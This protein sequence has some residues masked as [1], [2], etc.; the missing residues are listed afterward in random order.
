MKKPSS[1]GLRLVVAS[2]VAHTVSQAALISHDSFTGYTPG[3]LPAN[4]SPAVTGYTGSWGDAAFGNAEPA[5]TSGSLTYGDG[6]YA[7]SSGDM[8]SKGADAGGIGADNSGRTFRLLDSTLAVGATTSGT[9]YLSWLFQTGNEN[10]AANPNT[11]QT[12]ALWNGDAGTDSLR[13]FEAGIAGGDFA[14]GNYGYR[15]DS[16]TPVN[17]G[18]AADAT[19]HLFV[20]KFELNATADSDSVTVWLDP[21]LGGTGDPTGGFTLSGR[22]LAWDRLVL[23]DFASNSSAWDE[24]RW[25]SDFNSVTVPEPATAALGS[26]AVLI[27]LRRRRN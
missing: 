21:A 7:G 20:A 16:N 17:L 10:A 23:S 2:L 3:Y 6:L 1:P 14:T 26:L 12:L 15:V 8:V 9:L 19:V 4:P 25:G 13:D 18:V 24:V 27:L 11:Y 22:N 5:I